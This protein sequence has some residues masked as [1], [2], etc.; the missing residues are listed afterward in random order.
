[1]AIACLATYVLWIATKKRESYGSILYKYGELLVL[2]VGFVAGLL[3]ILFH[4]L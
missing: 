2:V 1:M 4:N 3:L